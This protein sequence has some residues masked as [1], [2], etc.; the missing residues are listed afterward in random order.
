MS[1]FGM[2]CSKTNYIVLKLFSSVCTTYIYSEIVGQTL[3]EMNDENN[4]I[5]CLPQ[6]MIARHMKE[7]S[8]NISIW[9]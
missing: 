8:L 3:I 2:G 1:T 7:C 4:Y 6:I 9:L 5:V